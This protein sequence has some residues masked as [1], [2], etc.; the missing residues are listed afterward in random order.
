MESKAKS[1]FTALA[2]LLA[3][4]AIIAV[5]LI[6]LW[7]SEDSQNENSVERF[8]VIDTIVYCKPVLKDSTVIRYVT[9][10]L[11]LA[12]THD[13]CKTS[14]DTISVNDVAEVEI[15]ITQKVYS[16]STYTAYV[17]GY[18][19]TLDS[20]SVYPRTTTTV[21]HDTGLRYKPP[22]RWGI[23][24]TG[25][26]GYCIGSRRLEPYIGIGITYSIIKF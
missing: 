6:R 14:P 2:I 17:S 24:I 7:E 13:T 11:P 1:L 5:L 8:T 10:N 19:T 22:N 23:G 4:T 3:Y 12:N 25:G 15:P 18:L 26:Y 21:I 16:D 20:I 9:A